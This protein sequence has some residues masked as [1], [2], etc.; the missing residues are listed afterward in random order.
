MMSL[1][2]IGNGQKMSKG[3]THEKQVFVRQGSGKARKLIKDFGR[4]VSLFGIAPCAGSSPSLSSVKSTQML[5]DICACQ[6][7]A[8]ESYSC[9]QYLGQVA[10]LFDLV[11][12]IFSIMFLNDLSKR[13]SHGPNIGSQLLIK[14]VRRRRRLNLIGLEKRCIR[15]RERRQL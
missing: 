14:K 7:D 8:S 15:L 3:P 12:H 11:K 2:S 10:H 5:V 4:L 6:L 13:G 1:C 9:I